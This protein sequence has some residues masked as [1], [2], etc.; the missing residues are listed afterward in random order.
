[1]ISQPQ[2]HPDQILLKINNHTIYKYMLT[3]C[4]QTKTR[5]M[6]PFT[7]KDLKHH[8]VMRQITRE[9]FFQSQPN[10]SLIG[11]FTYFCWHLNLH[12]WLDNVG[13]QFAGNNFCQKINYSW[14]ISYA[15]SNVFKI[16]QITW[17]NISNLYLII[18]ILWQQ[19]L[20]IAFRTQICNLS[21]WN[22]TDQH[23]LPSYH[24]I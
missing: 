8:N 16:F 9:K 23:L 15:N 4:I 14:E 18:L 19:N 6:V 10:F 22:I 7:T 2:T 17:Q 13:C 5:G 3:G 12:R 24:I 21:S 11:P 20:N 1:M